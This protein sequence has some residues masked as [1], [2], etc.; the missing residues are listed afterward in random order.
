MSSRGV[1]RTRSRVRRSPDFVNTDDSVTTASLRSIDTD[2]ERESTEHE[3]KRQRRDSGNGGD[4]GLARDEPLPG[5]QEQAPNSMEGQTS[6]GSGMGGNGVDEAQR[7]S[8][9]TDAPIGAVIRARLEERL[10]DLEHKLIDIDNRRLQHETACERNLAKIKED[11]EQTLSCC[12]CGD[13]MLDETNEKKLWVSCRNCVGLLC[14]AC[15]SSY[16]RTVFTS[17][18]EDVYDPRFPQNFSSPSIRNKCPT[19]RST[20][21]LDGPMDRGTP[22]KLIRLVAGKFRP[23]R[24][25]FHD[26][27]CDRTVEACVFERLLESS[28]LWH[29]QHCGDRLVACPSPFCAETRLLV[30]DWVLHADTCP[31]THYKQRCVNVS[32]CGNFVDCRRQSGEGKTCTGCPHEEIACISPGC[33]EKHP[34]AKMAAHF[35]TRHLN[36]GELVT[37]THMILEDIAPEEEEPFAWTVKGVLQQPKTVHVLVNTWH[38][39][40]IISWGDDT[41]EANTTKLA[42]DVACVGGGG[43]V[44]TDRAEA[45]KA[46]VRLSLSV[47]TVGRDFQRKR[48]DASGKTEPISGGMNVDGKLRM[49]WDINVLGEN[50]VVE[51]SMRIHHDVGLQDTLE[52]RAPIE[53]HVAASRAVVKVEWSMTM[54]LMNQRWA[55]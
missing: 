16:S 45:E 20:P 7:A 3:S 1:S 41:G 42:V 36:D 19:C 50:G 15:T 2:T 51:Q 25:R 49:F 55:R 32:R 46:S 40:A 8:S 6:N 54:S 10:R 44:V 23:T 48:L 53:V 47:L 37:E 5:T 26:L 31:W 18:P 4:G 52:M 43:N 12:S 11:E 9:D 33:M 38:N 22:Q 39:K 30:R 27:M 28:V 35:E 21:F 34:R 24:C 13:C 14:D 29:E 17:K